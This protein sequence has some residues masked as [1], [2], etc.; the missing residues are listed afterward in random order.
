MCHGPATIFQR[1]TPVEL[2]TLQVVAVGDLS[3]PRLTERRVGGG[4][5]DARIDHLTVHFEDGT[6][7]VPVYDRD[8][9]ANGISF[10]G[11]AL[12]VQLDSTTLIHS[13]QQVTCDRF[14][15]LIVEMR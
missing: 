2:V 5:A 11:P 3:Q 14:G 1:D 9:L 6:Q 13:D 12:V 4:L 15:N 8:K 10:L 7:T